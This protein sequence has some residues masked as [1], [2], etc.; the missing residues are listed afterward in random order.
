MN[1][2]LSAL[3]NLLAVVIGVYLLLSVFLYFRQ[4]SMLFLPEIPGREIAQTPAALG[5]NFESLE[6]ETAEN[7]K[8]GDRPRFWERLGKAA[9]K[10]WSIPSFRPS[11]SLLVK[12]R[13]D[14]RGE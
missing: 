5:M 4:G 12:M 2:L 10:P 11:F 6:L 9:E 14:G 1:S 3:L 8:I 13:S 7:R